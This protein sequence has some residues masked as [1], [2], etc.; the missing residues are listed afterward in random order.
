[1]MRSTISGLGTRFEE[2]PFCFK[3]DKRANRW[4]VWSRHQVDLMTLVSS[5]VIELDAGQKE[6]HAFG[7]SCDLT[8]ISSIPKQKHNRYRYVFG[9]E[10]R[11]IIVHY[12]VQIT[13]L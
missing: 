10:L 11:T 4:M 8:H 12:W 1:M 7:C 3:G 2:E 5:P 6:D 13:G 9:L